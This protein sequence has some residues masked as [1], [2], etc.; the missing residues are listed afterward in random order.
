MIERINPYYIFKKKPSPFY[1]YIDCLWYMYGAL[2]NQGGEYQP[3]SLTAR[4]LLTCWWIF[5]LVISSTYSG[6]LFAF[7]TVT[8]ETPPFDTL[9]GMLGQDDFKW[10]IVGKNII[11]F[12]FQNTKDSTQSAV[13][14]K[15]KLFNQSDP[16]V[17]SLDINVHFSKV[18]QGRYLY[19]G[20]KSVAD[21][22]VER[23]CDLV[24]IK[25]N[26]FPVEYAVGLVND[27][28][29][30]KLF[31]EQIIKMSEFGLLSIWKSRWWPTESLC[32]SQRVT[33]ASVISLLDLQSAFYLFDHT[34][35]VTDMK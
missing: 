6:N 12:L 32:N 10:G 33:A 28:A 31:S 5:T 3:K 13:W 22:W 11:E 17:L 8:K 16:T 25:E 18:Q 34:V 7:L 29:Y 30:T 15:I 24:K 4:T 2:I 23:Q 26:F 20:D 9:Q 1:G 35:S 14:E 19:I 21:F 27:S